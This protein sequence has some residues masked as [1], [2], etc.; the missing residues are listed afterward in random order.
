ML[1]HEQQRSAQRVFVEVPSHRGFG[2]REASDWHLA[3][4]W[5]NVWTSKEERGVRVLAVMVESSSSKHR[6]IGPPTAGEDSRSA[7]SLV[8]EL[9][10]FRQTEQADGE[11]LLTPMTEVVY[12]AKKQNMVLVVDASPYARTVKDGVVPFSL[13]GP[14]LAKCLDAVAQ[15]SAAAPCVEQLEIRWSLVVSFEHGDGVESFTRET[16]FDDEEDDGVWIPLTN[17]RLRTGDSTE[18]ARRR[19]AQALAAVEDRLAK[20]IGSHRESKRDATARTSATERCARAGL[21]GLRFLPLDAT[22]CVV[23]ATDG[24]GIGPPFTCNALRHDGIARA[25]KRDGV[26]LHVVD[27]GGEIKAVHASVSDRH[28]DCSSNAEK[29]NDDDEDTASSLFVDAV[30]RR[31][32]MTT[33]ALGYCPDWTSIGLLCDRA[34]GCLLSY[35]PVRDVLALAMLEPGGRRRVAVPR[36]RRSYGFATMQAGEKLQRQPR[37]LSVMEVHSSDINLSPSTNASSRK[38]IT[39]ARSRADQSISSQEEDNLLGSFWRDAEGECARRLLW[40]RSPLSSVSRGTLLAGPLSF[41]TTSVNSK[42]KAAPINLSS[43]RGRSRRRSRRLEH[44]VDGGLTAVS[45]GYEKGT[46]SPQRQRKQQQANRSMSEKIPGTPSLKEVKAGKTGVYVLASYYLPHVDLRDA[47]SARAVSLMDLTLLRFAMPEPKRIGRVTIQERNGLVWELKP[48]AQGDAVLTYRIEY[49]PPTREALIA[50]FRKNRTSRGRGENS[51]EATPFHENWSTSSPSPRSSSSPATRRSRSS[52][53]SQEEQHESPSRN[54][55]VYPDFFSGTKS[56]SNLDLAAIAT[57]ARGG[58]LSVQIDVAHA[59]PEMVKALGDMKELPELDFSTLEASLGG[60]TEKVVHDIWNFVKSFEEKENETA[61]KRAQDH[62]RESEESKTSPNPAGTIVYNQEALRLRQY[63]VSLQSADSRLIAVCYLAKEQQRR[64]ERQ[65][66]KEQEGQRGDLSSPHATL[67]KYMFD[68]L[69]WKTF[70]E[71]SIPFDVFVTDNNAALTKLQEAVSSDWG[72]SLQGTTASERSNASYAKLITRQSDNRY[73][74]IFTAL[75]MRWRCRTIV[76]ARVAVMCMR[77]ELED[78]FIAEVLASTLRCRLEKAGLRCLVG[79]SLLIET[80]RKQ[81]RSLKDC[82]KTLD[83]E[84]TTSSEMVI[85]FEAAQRWLRTSSTK[86]SA[87]PHHLL[88]STPPNLVFRAA[89]E[90]RIAAGFRL[91]YSPD[92]GVHRADFFASEEDVLVGKKLSRNNTA[93]P[94]PQQPSDQQPPPFLLHCAVEVT[95]EDNENE[96]FQL[97][98]HMWIQPGCT[99]P[100]KR[101]VDR[102][103]SALAAADAASMS[104]LDAYNLLSPGGE[105]LATESLTEALRRGLASIVDRAPRCTSLNLPTYSEGDREDNDELWKE[106]VCAIEKKTQTSVDDGASFYWWSMVT[107]DQSSMGPSSS[108]QIVVVRLRGRDEGTYALSISEAGV[109]DLL[110]PGPKAPSDVLSSEALAL[111][112]S[113]QQAH[114]STFARNV[115]ARSSRGAVDSTSVRRAISYCDW[116]LAS[117]DVLCALSRP[118]R[119][120]AVIVPSVAETLQADLDRVWRDSGFGP[121]LTSTGE[122]ARTEGPHFFV[123]VAYADDVDGAAGSPETRLKLLTDAGGS[124]LVVLKGVPRRPSPESLAKTSVAASSQLAGTSCDQAPQ[125]H[126]VR[127]T[128]MKSIASS[129]C[130]VETQGLSPEAFTGTVSSLHT[131]FEDESVAI[132]KACDLLRTRLEACIARASLRLLLANA[133]REQMEEDSEILATSEGCSSLE[134]VASWLND[135]GGSAQTFVENFKGHISIVALPGDS[136]E[137]VL[138]SLKRALQERQS[139]SD[140]SMPREKKASLDDDSKPRRKKRVWTTRTSSK[141]KNSEAKLLSEESDLRVQRESDYL[142]KLQRVAFRAVKRHGAD[143]NRTYVTV[144]SDGKRNWRNRLA[145]SLQVKRGVDKERHEPAMQ[146]NPQVQHS[147]YNVDAS[148]RKKNQRNGRKMQLYAAAG[149]KITPSGLTTATSRIS[150]AAPAVPRGAFFVNVSFAATFFAFRDEDRKEI[151][152]NATAVQEALSRASYV[153]SQLCLL[154]ELAATKRAQELLIPQ[155]SGYTDVAVSPVSCDMLKEIQLWCPAHRFKDGIRGAAKVI[156]RRAKRGVASSTTGTLRFAHLAEPVE[157][158]EGVFVCRSPADSDGKHHECCYA[159]LVHSRKGTLELRVYGIKVFSDAAVEA[160]TRSIQPELDRAS[161]VALRNDFFDN[162]YQTDSSPGM[163][164][165]P[166]VLPSTSP[167]FVRMEGRSVSSEKDEYDPKKSFRVRLTM[168]ARNN[169]ELCNLP[170]TV[171]PMSLDTADLA[172]FLDKNNTARSIFCIGDDDYSNPRDD[173]AASSLRRVASQAVLRSVLSEPWGEEIDGCFFVARQAS[174][175]A[176]NDDDRKY[177]RQQLRAVFAELP[178]AFSKAA[179][180]DYDDEKDDNRV[181]WLF[182]LRADREKDKQQQYSQHP[183]GAEKSGDADADERPALFLVEVRV[184]VFAAHQS[185]C[186]LWRDQRVVVWCRATATGDSAAFQDWMRRRVTTGLEDARI[187]AALEHRRSQPLSDFSAKLVA[188]LLL[189]VPCECPKLFFP[190]SRYT[191]CSVSE[192]I[193]PRWYVPRLARRA[194]R[195]F[196]RVSDED[197]C[198]VRVFYGGTS[199]GRSAV[200][201]ARWRIVDYDCAYCAIATFSA[202]QRTLTSFR[203]PYHGRLVTALSL[204]ALKSRTRQQRLEARLANEIGATPS[205]EDRVLLPSWWDCDNN[206]AGE[207]KPVSTLVN[208]PLGSSLLSITAPEKPPSLAK[209]PP[210][211]RVVLMRSSSSSSLVQR[212]DIAWKRESGYSSERA[213]TAS[214]LQH[215]VDTLSPETRAAGYSSEGGKTVAS[216]SLDGDNMASTREESASQSVDGMLRRRPPRG[217]DKGGVASRDDQSSDDESAISSEWR[218]NS[219]FREDSAT[220]KIEQAEASAVALAFFITMRRKLKHKATTRIFHTAEKT[221][222]ELLGV[223][224]RFDGVDGG[225]LSVDIC[226]DFDRSKTGSLVATLRIANKSNKLKYTNALA[227]WLEES[228]REVSSRL[229]VA[230]AR[231]ERSLLRRSDAILH[232]VADIQNACEDAQKQGQKRSFADNETFLSSPGLATVHKRYIWSS[233]EFF[234]SVASSRHERERE[235]TEWQSSFFFNRH[236]STATSFAESLDTFADD[237]DHVS[238]L[239]SEVGNENGSEDAFEDDEDLEWVAEADDNE[240]FKR[241]H[242]CAMGWSPLRK[243][244]NS[245]APPKQPHERVHFSPP[246]TICSELLGVDGGLIMT[247]RHFGRQ[248]LSIDRRVGTMGVVVAHFVKVV[249]PRRSRDDEDGRDV[250]SDAALLAQCQRSVDILKGTHAMKRLEELDVWE[251]SPAFVARAPLAAWMLYSGLNFDCNSRKDAH[252]FRQ[253][254]LGFAHGDVVG[255][256]V[257]AERLREIPGVARVVEKKKP[258]HRTIWLVKLVE[259]NPPSTSFAFQKTSMD[260]PVPVFV[261]RICVKGDCS[262]SK[263]AKADVLAA[264]YG[265]RL[266]FNNH[267]SVRMFAHKLFENLKDYAF[268]IRRTGTHLLQTVSCETNQ[269]ETGPSDN[270]EREELSSAP[271]DSPFHDDGMSSGMSFDSHIHFQDAT[272][273]TFD[274]ESSCCFP[275]IFSDCSNRRRRGLEQI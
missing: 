14:A 116:E 66:Q 40:R 250:E 176:V 139:W 72:P 112:N 34:G 63:A 196:E 68:G 223:P 26:A 19:L 88:K 82:A 242:R 263:I 243:G 1:E 52:T 60:S 29:V 108:P 267:L 61:T 256:W 274:Q 70:A 128:S 141:E 137:A 6:T 259:P 158:R 270:T 254:A 42:H 118:K 218:H 200:V 32:S 207:L 54:G 71:A 275:S 257:T 187:D 127:T 194:A 162:L 233:G 204:A 147:S 37:S 84:T 2:P 104:A 111:V 101:R 238:W 143:T 208:S 50:E 248:D 81:T 129:S 247:S 190:L 165:V 202:G 235:K 152:I 57:M 107:S 260:S 95:I 188:Q 163:R 115:L 45:L 100:K 67:G 30:D 86:L 179:V 185:A 205:D 265:P 39:S 80:E 126:F 271:I 237:E 13:I 164:R 228:A 106:L 195:D 201:V 90:N 189:H 148:D 142:E 98:S 64:R 44:G 167:S 136:D 157:N 20:R 140:I 74:D 177:L 255:G 261:I 87:K 224:I 105:L 46:P 38:S 48:R 154:G 77:K 175:A 123:R 219:P 12:A 91:L 217:Y 11:A 17:Q 198:D 131:V 251:R 73:S 253:A 93:P 186:Q 21:F 230:C 18:V 47:I 144:R 10:F 135:D 166:S 110:V 96:Q 23:I 149:F 94:P 232:M 119:V 69:E 220:V 28:S 138:I 273:R 75:S 76:T 62:R 182:A 178:S 225:N 246:S 113:A 24:N 170:Q 222:R 266:T 121:S 199:H 151:A 132:S 31:K 197:S 109:L 226:V 155:G 89:V 180:E 159:R 240:V 92:D 65:Q 133:D 16:V 234:S 49:K 221:R 191:R 236:V 244:M 258:C 173:A 153:A 79:S 193:I 239:T 56:P 203:H 172:L 59:S 124:K 9:E 156:E 99:V 215:D 213:T 102:L 264:T 169:V 249:R 160:V 43:K 211:V 227:H 241:L 168:L 161:L 15:A 58:S 145:L 85:G 134:A 114:A 55:D 269:E 4:L 146:R 78:P 22:S 117:P 122:R 7:Q 103:R 183:C 8:R 268:S 214:S 174:F 252:R 120:P 184:A 229:F 36:S 210:L 3:H 209:E 83:D 25:F 181:F 35:R 245:M 5:R 97:S 41:T 125:S 216:A 171:A 212:N 53:F 51:T 150:Q 33:S 206:S 262:Q 130:E 231:S 192:D 272:G 27:Y